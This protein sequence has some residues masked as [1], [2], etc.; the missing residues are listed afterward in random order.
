[1]SA[2]DSP[3]LILERIRKNIAGSSGN[4]S[5]LGLWDLFDLE[6]VVSQVLGLKYQHFL[7]H[8]G[9]FP[10][11]VLGKGPAWFSQGLSSFSLSHLFIF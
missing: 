4:C 1:M 11:C 8:K 6:E 7:L 3:L 5:V 10:V 9:H 2:G